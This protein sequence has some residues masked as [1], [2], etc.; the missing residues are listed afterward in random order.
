MLIAVVDPAAG[1]ATPVGAPAVLD[2]VVRLIWG[3]L[4]KKGAGDGDMSMLGSRALFTDWRAARDAV[5][6]NDTTSVVVAPHAV[7]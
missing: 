5:H 3:Q 4:H 1:V 2:V 7:V 6:R